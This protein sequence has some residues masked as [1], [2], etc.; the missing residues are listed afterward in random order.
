MF[1]SNFNVTET[2]M[3]DLDCL[4]PAHQDIS[5]GHSLF[6]LRRVDPVKY[7][8][9]LRDN[10]CNASKHLQGSVYFKSIISRSCPSLAVFTI[11]NEHW[12]GFG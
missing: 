2:G 12:K 9:V 1:L 4:D 5:T 3:G 7:V 11:S 6:H 8:L 10:Q